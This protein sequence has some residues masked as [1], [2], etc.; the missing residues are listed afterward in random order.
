MTL[1]IV[2]DA[3]QLARGE[4]LARPLRLGHMLARLRYYLETAPRLRGQAV[5]F[6]PFR[7]EP[8]SR[9]LMRE[10]Q[11]E[12]IRLTEK[13]TALLACLAQ[14]D[15]P[16]SRADLLAQ[17]WGYDERID[18][19]TLETHIYQLRRKMDDEAWLVNENGG[20]RLRRGAA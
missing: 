7:L 4:S 11:D 19:H 14:S 17:V 8:L 1:L 3:P 20:Y 16:L 15:T 2:G 5:A 6:G 18:T 10:G 12:P 9:R 13:E